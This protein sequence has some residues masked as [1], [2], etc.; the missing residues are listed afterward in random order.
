[1]RL[2]QKLKC[3]VTR[4]VITARKKWQLM[5]LAHRWHKNVCYVW[6]HEN[7]VAICAHWFNYSNH[8]SCQ[9]GHKWSTVHCRN[10]ASISQ[11]DHFI[12]E[13]ICWHSA[14]SIHTNCM[15]FNTHCTPIYKCQL[16]NIAYRYNYDRLR[17]FLDVPRWTGASSMFVLHG[18]P[19]FVAVIRKLTY[20]LC[21]CTCNSSNSLLTAYRKNSN[22]TCTIYT[23][24][25]G[26]ISGVHI[27]HVNY[28]KHNF[29]FKKVT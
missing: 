11:L 12:P 8:H 28:K 27:I 19:T 13:R 24:N 5:S 29:P 21:D 4:A 23:K 17:V 20:S 14:A 22:I 26:L 3:P 18:V 16:W 7:H 15:P 1:M 2:Q 10:S 25:R 9:R 6:S